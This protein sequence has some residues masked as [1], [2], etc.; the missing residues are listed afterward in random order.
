MILL[1]EDNEHIT[2]N[3][4]DNNIRINLYVKVSCALFL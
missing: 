1:D 3:F 2:G 4:L